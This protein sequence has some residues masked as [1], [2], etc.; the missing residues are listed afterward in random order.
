MESLNNAPSRAILDNYFSSLRRWVNDASNRLAK[1][2][3]APRAR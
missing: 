3:H 1:A 2:S